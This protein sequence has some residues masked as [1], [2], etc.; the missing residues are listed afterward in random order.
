MESLSASAIAFGVLSGICMLFIPIF[1][2]W[3]SS[4]DLPMPIH[5]LVLTGVFVV[6][7][8]NTVSAATIFLLNA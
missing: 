6:L 4:D 8:A 2:F 5:K 3:L 1:H 7:I